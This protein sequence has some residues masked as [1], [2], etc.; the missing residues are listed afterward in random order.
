[1]AGF[2]DNG[3]EWIAQAILRNPYL[4]LDDARRPIF[5]DGIDILSIKNEDIDQKLIALEKMGVNR[6]FLSAYGPSVVQLLDELSEEYLRFLRISNGIKTNR[7]DFS[8]VGIPLESH[9]HSSFKPTSMFV[10]NLLERQRDR[11]DNE[12]YIGI[13]GEPMRR[14]YL[15]RKSGKVV[16][17]SD[18]SELVFSGVSDLISGVCIG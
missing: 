15:A 14:L 6:S 8:L 18:E 17:R 4:D 1:M 5:F 7:H 12:I 2:G 10:A 11:K 16:A 13:L 3:R 9:T